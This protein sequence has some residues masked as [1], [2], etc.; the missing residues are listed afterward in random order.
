MVKNSAY[1]VLSPTP[2][3]SCSSRSWGPRQA[4]AHQPGSVRQYYFFL[5][6]FWWTRSPCLYC[7]YSPL[8]PFRGQPTVKYRPRWQPISGLAVYCRLGRW[9]N[10]NPGLKVYNL[11]PL[12]LSHHYTQLSHHYSHWATTTPNWAT[13]TPYSDSI[14]GPTWLTWVPVFSV[15]KRFVLQTRI[16]LQFLSLNSRIRWL[17]ICN[18]NPYKPT[19]EAR[20]ETA[21]TLIGNYGN[22][23]LQ[24]LSIHGTKGFKTERNETLPG[25]L[26]P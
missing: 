5:D 6:C 17:P 22:R 2:P 16:V 9:P 15:L 21:V 24:E 8:P 23:M 1:L 3:P 14:I 10:S 13:T 11:V 4:C 19:T 26:S 7:I 18:W 12:P 20:A 25:I